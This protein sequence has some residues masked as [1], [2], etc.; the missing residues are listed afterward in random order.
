MKFVF[1]RD[2]ILC[3]GW[4]GSKHQLTNYNIK[5][6]GQEQ[7]KPN[8]GRATSKRVKVTKITML[9]Y[10]LTEVITMLNFKEFFLLHL[11]NVNIIF[12]FLFEK[13]YQLPLTKKYATLI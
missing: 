11:K 1:S 13:V 8:G 7:A 6:V 5:A 2:V 4:L 3:G 9:M 10:G 12:L